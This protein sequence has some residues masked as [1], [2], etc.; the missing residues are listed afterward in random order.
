MPFVDFTIEKTLPQTTVGLLLSDARLSA[1][2]ATKGGVS[3]EIDEFG[4]ALG[5]AAVTYFEAANVV[6]EG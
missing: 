6:V 5:W 3:R 2:V 1:T 4:P